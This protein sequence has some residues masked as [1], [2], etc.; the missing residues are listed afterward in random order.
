VEAKAAENRRQRDYKLDQERQAKQ[1]AYAARLIEIEDEIEHQKRIMSDHAEENDRQNALAQKRQ[2]LLNLKT[3]AKQPMK[4]ARS[5]DGTEQSSAT[6]QDST[7]PKV[8]S[9]TPQPDSCTVSSNRSEPASDGNESE[10]GEGQPDWDKSEAKDDWKEQKELW[11][12][13]NKA[14]DALMSMIGQS[15]AHSRPHVLTICK[16]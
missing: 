12:A 5:Y 13:E 4:A 14:L 7:A 11:G 6:S 10:E 8:R 9:D 15:F 3:R 16:A 2:D 1:Q